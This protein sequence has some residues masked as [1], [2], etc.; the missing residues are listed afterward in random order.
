MQFAITALRLRLHWLQRYPALYNCEKACLHAWPHSEIPTLQHII[1]MA[2]FQRVHLLLTPLHARTDA[3]MFSSAAN[4]PE[5]MV[6]HRENNPGRFL[7]LGHSGSRPEFA[8]ALTAALT[9]YV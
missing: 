3:N 1:A 9:R 5:D 4:T 2:H 7:R 8:A 6:E